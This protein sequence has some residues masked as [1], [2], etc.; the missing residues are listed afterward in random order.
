MHDYVHLASDGMVKKI[1][2]K[3]VI[4]GVHP[5]WF[6]FGEYQRSSSKK[7]DLPHGPTNIKLQFSIKKQNK[8]T[9]V[10]TLIKLQ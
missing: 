6:V 3:F 2:L 10:T 8:K 9:A 1:V 5:S 4:L 7:R